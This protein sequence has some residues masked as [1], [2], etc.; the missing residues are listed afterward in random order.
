MNENVSNQP[1]SETDPVVTDANAS[2]ELDQAVDIVA[3]DSLDQDSIEAGEG[4]EATII[5]KLKAAL[6]EAEK[7]SLIAAA[8]LE[9]FRKRAS[10]NAQEQIKYAA[11]PMMSELLECVDNLDRAIDSAVNDA[12][13]PGLLEGVKMVS[14]QILGILK[15]NHCEAIESVGQPFDPN[16]HQAVQMNP[17]ND[18]PTNT[19][20]LELRTGYKLHDRVIRPSQVF[21]S[22]GN[23]KEES[24]Q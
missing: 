4:T 13:N 20:M 14:S 1:N 10:K 6:E 12:S 16:L 15:A 9:N 22:T 3:A 7:K 5:E 24:D 17:S 23:Q 21:V 11:L 2:D 18:F 19:V 8:D